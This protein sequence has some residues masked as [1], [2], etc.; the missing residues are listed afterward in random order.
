MNYF[1][2]IDNEFK[3]FPQRESPINLKTGDIRIAYY[4]QDDYWIRVVV[5]IWSATT[6]FAWRLPTDEEEALAKTY[7]L[8]NT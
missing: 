4:S 6:N 8:L 3:E 7:L 2:I 1:Y 5:S